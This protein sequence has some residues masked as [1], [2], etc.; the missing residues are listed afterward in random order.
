MVIDGIISLYPITASGDIWSHSRISSVHWRT[1][2]RIDRPG[3]ADSNSSPHGK[4]CWQRTLYIIPP[5]PL[6]W[7][8]LQ[9][10]WCTGRHYRSA[11]L[12]SWLSQFPVKAIMIW[13]LEALRRERNFLNT[14]DCTP[15]ISVMQFHKCDVSKAMPKKVSLYANLQR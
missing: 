6:L 9:Y 4:S 7:K 5:Y 11:C 15:A 2:N 13:F 1:W 10:L 12:S 14:F 8:L 3:K